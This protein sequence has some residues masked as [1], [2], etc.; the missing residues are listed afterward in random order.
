MMETGFH[1]PRE[2]A[3]RLA[4]GHRLDPDGGWETSFIDPTDAAPM[5]AGGGGL[6]STASDYAR[7]LHM[8]LSGGTLDGFRVLSPATLAYMM[9]DHLAPEVGNNLDILPEGYGFG[10]GF[11]VR[12]QRGIAP[13]PGSPGDCW[14]EGV[15]GTSFFIDPAQQLYAI[16]MVQA[17]GRREHY[18][19]MFRSLVYAAVAA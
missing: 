10:L 4:G 18:R 8:I 11:A 16:L 3:H 9:S 12:R 7:F 17:P 15:A 14:W 6:V 13:F 5:Q 19:R 2:F 1:L